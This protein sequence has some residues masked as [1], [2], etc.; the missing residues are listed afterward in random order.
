MKSSVGVVD[1][2]VDV[3]RLGLRL[4][5]PR[6]TAA[7]V[8]DTGA[9]DLRRVN[10]RQQAQLCKRLPPDHLPHPAQRRKRI[11]VVEQLDDVVVGAAADARTAFRVDTDEAPHDVTRPPELS[12]QAPVE[13]VNRS[14]TTVPMPLA[15]PVTSTTRPSTW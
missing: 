1:E 5:E 8:R 11:V 4:L 2:G 15:P 14:T 12:K 10:R 7:L 3:T 6:V 13:K 9:P